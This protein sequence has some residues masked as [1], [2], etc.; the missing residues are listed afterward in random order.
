[1]NRRI[2][3]PRGTIA[4]ANGMLSREWAHFFEAIIGELAE[5]KRLKGYDS[6]VGTRSR[7]AFDT[8]TVTTEELAETVAAI[9][10]DLGGN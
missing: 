2:P 9:I 1:M 4:D 10:D 7:A 3:V 5:V 8:S 6:P